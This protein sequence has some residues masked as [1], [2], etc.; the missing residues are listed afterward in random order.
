M[1]QCEECEMWRLV[2]SKFKLTVAER[3]TLQEALNTLTYTCGAQLR[4]LGLGG[5]LQENVE[6]RIIRCY[7]PVEK[8]YFSVGSYEQICIY[9][10]SNKNLTMVYPQC[11]ACSDKEPI[12]NVNC[13]VCLWFLLKMHFL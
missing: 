6:M 12:K 3:K 13:F 5:R 10:C 8:L 7:K 1:I 11:S 2:Y 9:C 4:D